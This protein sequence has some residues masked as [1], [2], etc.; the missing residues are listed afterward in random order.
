DG[1]RLMLG[2]E[3][4]SVQRRGGE[5]ILSVK[6]PAGDG[7]HA[8]D[9]ILV[10]TGRTPNVERLSLDAAGVHFDARRGVT[11]NDRLR[12]T[13][14]RVFAAGDICSRFQFTHAADAL[15]RIVVQN[16]L[17]HGRARA[18]RL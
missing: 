3:V 12:T 10:A 5:K 17:F 13:N 15:A 16:A 14:R 8:V 4:Q 18:S 1:V 9:E 6:Q 2:S 11:V 7:E